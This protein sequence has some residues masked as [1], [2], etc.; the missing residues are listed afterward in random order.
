MNKEEENQWVTKER[1][2][3]G[4]RYRRALPY[5][6]EIQLFRITKL[7]RER[8]RERRGEEPLKTTTNEFDLALEGSKCG[9]YRF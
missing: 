1:I 7:L 6:V 5:R 2:R 3:I 4:S 8:E 9:L